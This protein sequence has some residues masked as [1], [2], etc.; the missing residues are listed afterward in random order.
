MKAY[1]LGYRYQPVPALSFDLALYYNDYSNLITELQAHTVAN[2]PLLQTT[3]VNVGRA[4]SHGAELSVKWR[5]VRH[6]TL[7]PG[8][9]EL[10]GSPNAAAVNPRHE[11]NV[12]S[13]VD[14]PHGLEFD[15]GLYHYSALPVQASQ[16]FG[17]PD[18]GVST[19]NR[20]DIGVAW[21]ATS[22]WTFA[23]W[24]RNLQSEQHVESLPSILVGPAGEVPRSFV[25][26]VTWQQKT[27][28]LRK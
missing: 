20:V 16:V 1:E 27:E 4:Q 11:F 15:S 28:T 19:L 6:W 17:V 14:M 26:K 24:A 18:A 10:R 3:F 8:V 21:H 23:V 2:S 9:T 5:P 22:Q 25:F 7:S 13:R 12:Q